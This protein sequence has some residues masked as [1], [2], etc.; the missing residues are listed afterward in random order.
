[1]ARP[2]NTKP[3]GST[4]K[5]SYERVVKLDAKGE[6][7]RPEDARSV[8]LLMATTATLVYL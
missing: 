3:K 4:I 2:D 6:K 7:K 1:L 8:A 5:I